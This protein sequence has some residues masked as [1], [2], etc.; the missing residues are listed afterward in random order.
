MNFQ[1]HR[2]M[3]EVRERERERE[4]EL[5]EREMEERKRDWEVRNGTVRFA[6]AL[7]IARVAITYLSFSLLFTRDKQIINKGRG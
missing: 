3:D 2:F 6:K 1:L 5:T 4:R 7:W